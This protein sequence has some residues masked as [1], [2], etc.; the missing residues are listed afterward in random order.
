MEEELRSLRSNH[1]V[2]SNN[3]K[4]IKSDINNEIK[5]NDE[6]YEIKQSIEQLNKNVLSIK[7]DINK[8][9]KKQIEFENNNK[10]IFENKQAILQLKDM[11]DSF[12]NEIIKTTLDAVKE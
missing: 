5:D 6:L 1:P 3:I 10:L 4:E 7:K 12:K 8:I 11:N 9:H 2:I